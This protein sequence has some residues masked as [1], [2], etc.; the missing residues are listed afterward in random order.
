MPYSLIQ[1]KNNIPYIEFF[2]NEKCIAGVST[3]KGG[4]S[5]GNYASLNLGLNTNDDLKNVQENRRRF[6]ETIA[7]NCT[8]A[9]LTQTHS[10]I[11][12]CVDVNFENGCEGDAL[13]THE[14]NVLLSITTADCGAIVLHNR[15][16]TI[17][18]AIHCGWRGLHTQIIEKTIHEMSAFVNPEEL[19]AYIAPAIGQNNYEVGKEFFDFFPAEYIATNNDKY[20]FNINQ[21]I[22]H[23]LRKAYIGKVINTDFDTFSQSDYFFSYRRDTN[24]GR[25]ATFVGILS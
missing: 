24:T 4:V 10:N 1:T 19:T 8:V 12:R 25:F 22:V 13:F 9:Y 3:R 20:F 7:P 2:N 23:S 11:V 5:T 14:R 15:N 17:V 16:F 21:Y 18:A 6:F